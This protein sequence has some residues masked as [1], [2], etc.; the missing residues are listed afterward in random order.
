MKHTEIQL[1]SLNDFVYGLYT[2]NNTFGVYQKNTGVKLY[3]GNDGNIYLTY[4]HEF[5]GDMGKRIEPRYVSIDEFG[6]VKFLC[7]T[8][9]IDELR[10][11]FDTLKRLEF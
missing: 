11:F 2:T 4:M 6:E 10:R 9:N 7:E 5:S 1:R 3:D 8:G